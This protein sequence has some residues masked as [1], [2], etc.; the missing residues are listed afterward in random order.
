MNLSPKQLLT[1][2][3]IGLISWFVIPTITRA[4]GVADTGALANGFFLIQTL[5]GFGGIVSLFVGARA[6]RQAR[7]STN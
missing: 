2:G 5:I 4:F 3:V 7:R 1:L 6:W